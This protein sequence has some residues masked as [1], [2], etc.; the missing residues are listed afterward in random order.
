MVPSILNQ[1]VHELNMKKYTLPIAG[2]VFF[3]AVGV[4]FYMHKRYPDVSCNDRGCTFTY[5]LCRPMPPGTPCYKQTLPLTESYGCDANFM[6]YPT[7]AHKFSTIDELRSEAE[8][9]ADIIENK[10]NK[11]NPTPNDECRKA[12][13]S[14]FKHVP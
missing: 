8:D 12:E 1:R 14:K 10:Y 5:E 4:W 3:V 13:E 9:R 2:A 7:R 11:T 6:P